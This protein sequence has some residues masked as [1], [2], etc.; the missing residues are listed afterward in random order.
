MLLTVE[1]MNDQILIKRGFY[2]GYKCQVLSEG[3]YWVKCK[4]LYDNDG[5]MALGSVDIDKEDLK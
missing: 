1:D 4:Q 5:N 2:E 3:V